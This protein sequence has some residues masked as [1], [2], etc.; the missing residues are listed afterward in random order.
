LQISK[1]SSSGNAQ[2]SIDPKPNDGSGD[3][4]FRFFR[5]TNTSGNV[6]FYVHKGDG[7][8]IVNSAIRGNGNS[9]LNANTGDVGIGKA[10]PTEKLDVN[11]NVKATYFLGD[12]SLLQNLPQAPVQ[13]VN[14]QTGVVTYW[15]RI[16]VGLGNV[17]N[18]SD[19]G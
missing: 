12:G 13:S 16:D 11:G 4:I 8:G 5:S 19:L 7:S 10:N 17:D 6:G 15:I 9:Y 18:T 2:I 3:A 14:G 1:N